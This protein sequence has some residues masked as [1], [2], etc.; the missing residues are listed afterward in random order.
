MNAWKIPNTN[1][2]NVYDIKTNKSRVN[3]VEDV[4]S[5]NYFY[6]MDFSEI[7]NTLEIDPS[8]IDPDEIKNIENYLKI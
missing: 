1:Q 6:D 7:L 4:A 2:I 3:N 5:E 8:N